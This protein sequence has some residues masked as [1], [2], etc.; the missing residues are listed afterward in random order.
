MQFVRVMDTPLHSVSI[1]T[2]RYSIIQ[3]IQGSYF[4]VK[5]LAENKNDIVESFHHG[6]EY[7]RQK[8]N[9]IKI[10]INKK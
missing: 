5:E 6:I 9:I 2:A 8:N 4:G 3:E 10:R 7:T 1:I